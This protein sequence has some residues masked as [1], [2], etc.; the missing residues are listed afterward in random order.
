MV[1]LQVPVP[2]HAPLQPANIEPEFGV[3]MSVRTVPP[4]TSEKHAVPQLKPSGDD[5]T[6][7]LPAP[8]LTMVSDGVPVGGGGGP[9]AVKTAPTLVAAFRV[10]VQV[11]VPEQAPLQPP[12]VDPEAGVAV[13]ITLVP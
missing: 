1:S 13:S 5:V 4:R 7:P 9:V 12:K 8:A 3:A 11:P 10:T 2:V 6:T